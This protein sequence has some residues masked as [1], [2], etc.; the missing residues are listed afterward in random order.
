MLVHTSGTTGSPRPFLLTNRNIEVNVNALAGIGLLGPQDRVLLPLPLHHVYPLSSAC[1]YPRDPPPWFCRM[2]RPKI[3]RA[4]ELTGATTMIGVP[5]FNEALVAGMEAQARARAHGRRGL[6]RAAANV[7]RR[8]APVRSVSAASCF[9]RSIAASSLRLLVSAGAKL[10]EQ[11]IW[12]LEG[13][14]SDAFRI[15]ARRNGFGVHRQYTLKRRI[16][17]EGK[18]LG[19]GRVRIANAGPEGTGEIQL[20]GPAVFDGYLDNPEANRAAFTEDGWF[21]TGDLG[22]PDATD[23]FMSRAG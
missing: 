7:D 13:L 11:V 16:G 18:P 4:L 6:F 20:Q 22:R 3:V 2:H 15:R 12:K 1:W 19:K 10:E 9:R 21:R 5:R 8:A 23:T 14:V 17:S